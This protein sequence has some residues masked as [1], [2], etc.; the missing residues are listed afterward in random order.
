MIIR[1]PNWI[2]DCIMTLPAIRALKENSPQTEIV[3]LTKPHLRDIYQHIPEIDKIITLPDKLTLKTLL[4]T[5]SH[6]RNYGFTHGILFTNSFHSALLFKLAGIKETVGYVKDGRRFLLQ[7]RL[8]FPND[9]NYHDIYF[10]MDIV[11]AFLKN[12]TGVKPQINANTYSTSPILTDSERAAMASILSSQGVDTT[13]P[14]VAIA[15][16]A[17]YGT[18]KT[19]LPERFGELIDRIITQ[20]P[21]PP[22]VFL[23]GSGNEKEKISRILSTMRQKASSVFNLA[24]QFSLRQTMAVLSFCRLFVGNDSG[25][26]HIA[27]GLGIPSVVL[28]GPTPPNKSKP[29]GDISIV[30]IHP[31][32]CAPCKHR[33]CPSDHACMKAISVNEVY[34]ALISLGNLHE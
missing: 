2:G 24:G 3:L 8:K 27:T 4:K 13:Q 14:I 15:P 9:V 25:L 6:I 11:K 5:A 28:F 10:Y 19:W 33:D 16:S 30:I 22:T 32:S 29:R 12:R 1:T 21:V 31:Q 18:A 34:G 23:L 7:T 26:M 17:A 20:F